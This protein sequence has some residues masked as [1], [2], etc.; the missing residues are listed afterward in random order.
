MPSPEHEAVVQMLLAGDALAGQ[1]LKEQREGY[2]AMLGQLPI[3]D[4]VTIEPFRIEHIDADWVS[5][6]ASRADTAVLYLHGGGYVIG[7]N[8]AYREFAARIARASDAR[9]CVI[10]YRLAPENPFPAA[11]EDAVMAYHWLISQGFSASRIA[12][13]GDSAGGG[14][15][16]AVIWALKEAG[17]SLPACGVCFSPWADL[18]GTG[19]SAQ[20]GAVDDPLV[21][22]DELEGMGRAYAGDDLRNPLASPIYADYAGFPP[23]LI[24]VGTR[25]ILL[26]DAVRVAER[27]AAA[28]VDVEL[29]KG[30]DLIHV[31]PVLA[32][33]APESIT[34]L[35][36]MAEFVEA[37]MA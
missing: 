37:R 23:L 35:S 31:W 24:Q 34:A 20:P 5:V 16:L 33:M 32:P 12:I 18:E 10:H 8:V 3:A 13:A 25:E 22:N 15:T 14:L 17:D 19:A 7:S 21:T 29:F 11:L 36:R 30:E 6:P 2:E 28:G 26:D 1:G 9:V 4:D 27:A